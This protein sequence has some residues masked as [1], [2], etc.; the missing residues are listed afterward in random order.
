MEKIYERKR[1]WKPSLVAQMVKHKPTMRETLVWTQG[2]ED[3]GEGNGNQLHHS[4]LEI[5][6]DGGMEK[7]YTVRKKKTRSWLWLRLWTPYCQI[8]TKIEESR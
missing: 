2:Q 3:P 6:V 4:C 1:K 5:P 8:Q 7:I